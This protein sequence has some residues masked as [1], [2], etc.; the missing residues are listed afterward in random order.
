M[1]LAILVV[2]LVLLVAYWWA[3]AG[4][5]DALLHFLCVVIAGSMAIA[6]WEPITIG[7]LLD[8]EL[9]HYGWGLALGGLFLVSLLILRTIV[10][11][12][13]PFR[14]VLPRWSDWAFGSVLGLGSGVLTI[15]MVLISMGH[16]ASTREMIDYEG[17]KREPSSELP[18]QTEPGSVVSLVMASTG[19]FFGM[20]SDHAFAPTFGQ[21]SL[22]AWRPDI[23]GDGGSLLRDSVE[24]GKGKSFV[25]PKGISIAGAFF[26]PT[27]ILGST[28]QGTGAYA[29][30]VSAKRPSYDPSNGF[31][32]SASQARLIDGTTGSSVFPVEFAQAEETSGMSLVRYRFQGDAAYMGT[33]KTTDE[34]IAC[35]I[36]PAKGLNR[37]AGGQLFLQIKGLRFAL[38]QLTEGA[39]DMAKA[40]QSAGSKIELAADADTPVIP[41][42]E[43]RMDSSLQGAG[44]EKNGLPGS[45]VE[46]EG[47]L[48]SG[49][50]ERFK[51]DGNVRSDV[52]SIF[53]PPGS[54]IVMLKCTRD[55]AVDLFNVNRTR[56]DA[57]KVGEFGVPML[58]D[59]NSNVYSPCGYILKNE[60]N[61]EFE[62]YLEPPEEGF[63]IKRFRRAATGGELNIIYRIPDG[64][65]VKLVV[66]SDPAKGLSQG[67]IV[68]STTL[69]VG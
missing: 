66:L 5:F 62:I 14:P 1:L 23:A 43:L 8:G 63:T 59:A 51:R 47:R 69:P 31:T 3:N 20:L 50:A 48:M 16:V 55:T 6:L 38:P 29:V 39:Q 25:G 10:D 4:V 67:R 33:P 58:V 19:W 60:Q 49:A 22:A 61:G 27:F 11:K 52:N 53:A 2:L 9:T 54:K 30:L 65:V 57:E 35:L 15:G 56:K 41:G 68:G 32:L 64:T 34:T 12:A 44:L 7:F 40:V 24:K 45:L 42:T 28:T 18:V 37:T 46:S 26:D 17:W 21:A 13:C 36:F